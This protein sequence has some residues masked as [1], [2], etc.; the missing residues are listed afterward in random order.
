MICLQETHQPAKH[1]PR[2]A[3]NIRSAFAGHQP[4]PTTRGPY[5]QGVAVITNPSHHNL[6]NIHALPLTNP[7]IISAF[8][9]TTPPL[10]LINVYAPDT[11]QPAAALTDFLS[12]LQQS[13]DLTPTGPLVIVGDINRSPTDA[14]RDRTWNAFI[15]NNS[16]TITAPTNPTNHQAG[17]IIDYTLTRNVSGVTTTVTNQTRTGMQG[18]SAHN[19]IECNIRWRGRPNPTHWILPNPPSR[20]F[21]WAGPKD[22][23]IEGNNPAEWK[24]YVQHTKSLAHAHPPI[25]NI[26]QE[27]DLI[28]SIIKQA[29]AKTKPES[30]ST[31][32]ITTRPPTRPQPTNRSVQD[33]IAD[34]QEADRERMEERA[35]TWK[36]K[37]QSQEQHREIK[38]R[39]QSTLNKFFNQ[40]KQGGIPKALIHGGIVETKP[41]Q[42]ATI[43]AKQYANTSQNPQDGQNPDIPTA[44]PL[45]VDTEDIQGAILALGNKAPGPDGI[46]AP[47]YKRAAPQL[48]TRIA[49]LIQAVINEGVIPEQWRYALVHPIFKPGGSLTNPRDYRP[50]SLTPILYRALGLVITRQ[51]ILQ[52]EDQLPTEQFGYKSKRTATMQV[53]CLI[54]DLTINTSKTAVLLD[55]SKAYDQVPRALLIDKLLQM[56]VHPRLVRCI[57]AA[58]TDTRITVRGATAWHKTSSGVR[59]GCSM[60]P[61]LFTIFTANWLSSWAK[62]MRGLQWSPADPPTSDRPANGRAQ[63][64]VDDTAIIGDTNQHTQT[65]TT[66][67]EKVIQA[68]LLSL[69]QDK[70][71]LVT[72]LTTSPTFTTT[73]GT[74]ITPE[75]ST[76]Y[77]GLYLGKG[78]QLTQEILKAKRKQSDQMITTLQRSGLLHP[79]QPARA[80]ATAITLHAW[81]KIQYGIEIW[82]TLPG[83]KPIIARWLAYITQTTPTAGQ[84]AE[85]LTS[86]RTAAGL[87]QIACAR[88][89]TAAL[90]LSMANTTLRAQLDQTPSDSPLGRLIS[91]AKQLIDNPIYHTQTLDSRDVTHL[92]TRARHNLLLQEIQNPRSNTFLSFITNYL[93]ED[94][95]KGTKPIPPHP[96]W[97]SWELNTRQI[98]ALTISLTNMA[99][100]RTKNRTTKRAA[101]NALAAPHN[102]TYEEAC[103]LCTIEYLKQIRRQIANNSPDI[104]NT[105]RLLEDKPKGTTS[106]IYLCPRAKPTILAETTI[107]TGLNINWSLLDSLITQARQEAVTPQLNLDKDTDWWRKREVPTM[108]ALARLTDTGQADSTDDRLKTLANY[109]TA[110]NRVVANIEEGLEANI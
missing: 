48:I 55:I 29:A 70:Y 106:H 51:L 100:T 6:W 60:A 35:A 94:Q 82:G 96:G 49:K 79:A 78:D 24:T 77:L 30:K 62:E 61:I 64:Y 107:T 80:A 50:I 45:L 12:K 11:G 32:Q 43:L 18:H 73:T 66:A 109:I 86:K 23:N 39:L 20:A 19:P 21:Q 7:R 14:R 59:Q 37:R 33:I 5:Y 97:R 1:R 68:N 53:A 63:M 108:H 3:K 72:A 9:Q 83:A 99:P 103:P 95:I 38:S 42:L 88:L 10:H 4:D 89:H 65:L 2:L 15:T 91:Q 75:E 36:N 92:L 25:A 81:P 102:T 98:R 22:L 40:A 41:R 56:K 13:L 90:R 31:Q 71:K 69:N 74:V 34:M 87:T 57:A 105:T 58:H 46:K 85:V 104:I 54:Q 16:L 101:T 84:T 8:S 67:M 27:H 93:T 52:I 76:R 44:Q 26:Q 17:T 28:H 110:V 47:M